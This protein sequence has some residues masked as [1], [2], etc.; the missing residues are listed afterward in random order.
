[1]NIF[2]DDHRFERQGEFTYSYEECTFSSTSL[3]DNIPQ[4]LKERRAEEI[5]RIQNG[6]SADNNRR[7]IGNVERVIVDSREGDYYVARS[8]YDSPE[9]DD[10]ILID[11]SERRLRRGQ[12]YTVRITDAEDYDLYAT[13]I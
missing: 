7:R 2:L 5:M 8:Q 4:G 12:F 11:A 3:K 13:V 1:M 9:V 10:E 6:V